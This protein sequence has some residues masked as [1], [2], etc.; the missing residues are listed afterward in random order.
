MKIPQVGWEFKCLP[1]T[2]HLR[3]PRPAEDAAPK[4]ASDTDPY[5]CWG[6]RPRRQPRE[7]G[8]EA[9]ESVTYGG[10]EQALAIPETQVLLFGKPD[11][12]PHR[13][14]GVALARGASEAEARDRADRAAAA[15]A[16]RNDGRIRKT[17]GAA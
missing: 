6:A 11:A 5:G 4:P 13:R 15:I 17:P 16:V 10:L 8:A 12:R 14:M 1:R 9:A 3:P 2:G 7:P